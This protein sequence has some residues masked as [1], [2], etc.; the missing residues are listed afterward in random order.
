MI[1]AV[2]SGKGGTG[3]TTVSTNLALYLSE[4]QKIVFLDLDVEEPNAHIFLQ[5]ENIQQ[6][7]VNKIVPLVNY[8]KCTF[9]GECAKICAFN[10]IAVTKNEVMI[11]KELCHSCGACTY[12]CPE[13]AIDE[14]NYEV[15]HVKISKLPNLEF[16]EGN[17]NIG[18]VVAPIIIKSVK[19]HISKENICILDAP[20]GSSCSVVET[21]QD[22]DFCILVTEP[23]P[24]GLS[25]LNIMVNLLTKLNIPSGII[26]NQ[27]EE[28]KNIIDD[29]ARSK[30]IPVLARI[31]FDRD[32]AVSYSTG[33][34]FIKELPVYRDLFASIIPQIKELIAK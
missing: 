21:V 30:N 19:S 3:K 11:F 24:F 20:P 26:I 18:E 22:T 12:L 25:D 5:P 17:L 2:A 31:P 6:E 28:G 10:A 32:I 13:N 29:Y 15:G 33:I 1:I 7:A 14:C 27:Y 9:C 23:T 34:P 8:E 16:F 4:K